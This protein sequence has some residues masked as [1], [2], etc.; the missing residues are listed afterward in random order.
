MTTHSIVR[1]VL[2]DESIQERAS[3]FPVPTR[4]CEEGGVERFGRFGRI[5]V[6]CDCCEVCLGLVELSRLEVDA[7]ERGAQLAVSVGRC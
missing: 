4:G 2:L 5:G 7:T 6:C 3:R 1:I